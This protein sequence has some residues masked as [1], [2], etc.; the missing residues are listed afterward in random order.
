[1][2]ENSFRDFVVLYLAEGYKRGRNLVSICNSD[3]AVMELA[4]AHLSVLADKDLDYG[5]QYHR[6]QDPEELKA[7]WAARL[8]ISAE[9][10]ALQRK[11]NSGG[12]KGRRWRSQYGV[13][14]IRTGD[15]QLRARLEAWMDY[16]RYGWTGSL[17]S[18]TPLFILGT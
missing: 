16:L 14:T 3:P 9:R 7:F 10:I 6:D 8:G 1:L 13:L 17:S 11:S 18:E 12:L 2:A 5:L 4:Q 15:T